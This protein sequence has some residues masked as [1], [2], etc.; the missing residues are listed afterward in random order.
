MFPTI[1]TGDLLL[2][3]KVTKA[4]EIREGQIVVFVPRTVMAGLSFEKFICH[5]FLKIEEGRMITKG[6]S[7]THADPWTP[8]ENIEGVVVSKV[9]ITPEGELFTYEH[10]VEDSGTLNHVDFLLNELKELEKVKNISLI[11]KRKIPSIV[12]ST[13]MLSLGIILSTM[14]F[15]W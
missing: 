8:V 13:V 12:Q 6:D 11:S 2:Y 4:E 15:F 14:V 7:L 10:L 3:K 9:Q 1:K 5:R